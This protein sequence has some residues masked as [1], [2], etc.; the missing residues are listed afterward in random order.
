MNILF[1]EDF[2][3]ESEMLKDPQFSLFKDKAPWLHCNPSKISAIFVKLKFEINE[4]LLKNFPNLKFII[5]PTTGM[6]HID[7]SYCG[8][9]R[10]EVITLQPKDVLEIFSTTEI[11]LWHLI[12][13]TRSASLY[14]ES[15][16]NRLWNR[17]LYNSNSL[18][19]YTVGIVGFGRIGRQIYSVLKCLGAKTLV[20]DEN[21]ME[22]SDLQANEVAGSI[23]ELFEKCSLVTIHISA[24]EE[25]VGLFS[26]SLFSRIKSKPFYLVNTSRGNL[27]NEYDLIENLRSGQVSAY[28]TDTVQG[29]YN[30][31]R[32]IPQSRLLHEYLSGDLPIY[33]TPHIAGATQDSILFA[34]KT[35]Y[36]EFTKKVAKNYASPNEKVSE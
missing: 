14:L 3:I 10:I 19:F 32:S 33:I 26:N 2:L 15:T 8:K 24:K 30:S 35:V 20:Y 34:E 21:R 12:N 13:L 9:N 7:S 27:I 11:T 36:T 23:E 31:Q 22:T 28:A 4:D 16:Q 6:D 18:K 29:E 5:S 17:Y 25:N 1:L